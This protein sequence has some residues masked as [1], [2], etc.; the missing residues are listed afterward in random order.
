MK[1]MGSVISSQNKQVLHVFLCRKKES[2]PLDNKCLTPNMIY[3]AQTT[4]NT[5]EEH[6]RHLGGAETSFKESYSNHTRDFKHKKH[7]KCTKLSKYI[8]SLKNQGIA[9]IVKW[10]IVKKLI[11]KFHRITSNGKA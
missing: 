5:N 9:P 1:N 10:R 8:W 11:V 2:C 4:N 3:L 7:I 6:K